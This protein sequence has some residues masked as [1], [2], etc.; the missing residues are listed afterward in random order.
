MAEKA[1]KKKGGRRCVAG[2]PKN[3]SCS[4]NSYTPGITMHKFPDDPNVRSLWVK[5]VRRHRSDFHEPVNKYACLC[6][7]YFEESCFST[8]QHKDV[9][10]LKLRRFLITDS[11]PTRHTVLPPGSAHRTKK[12][13]GKQNVPVFTSKSCFCCVE[14]WLSNTEFTLN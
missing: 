10:H 11:I 2:A 5:F 13:R 9:A 12:T 4:N 3:T 14:K 6:S 8:I 7:A 1:R